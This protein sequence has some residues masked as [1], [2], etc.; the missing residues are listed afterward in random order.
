MADVKPRA[1]VAALL[2]FFE[3]PTGDAFAVPPEQAVAYF[4]AKGLVPT[5]SY[6][7][8]L[9]EAHDHGFTVA[10]MMNIDMLGQV[11]ASL[12][13]A[14]ANGTPFKEWAD[15]IIPM[16]QSG[17]WWGRKAVLDPL[18]GQPMIAQLGSPWR[19]ETIFRTNMQ[20]AY[21]AGQWQEI[22]AQ[23][24][25]APWLMYDAVDDLRTRPMHASWD[26]KVLPVDST[27]WNSHYPPN[28]WNCRCGVIQLADDELEGLGLTP[29]TPPA[30]G[31]YT[32]S[33]PRTGE[34]EQ[35]PKGLD[36]GFD[37]NAGK[38]Y[39]QDLQ[40]LQAEKIAA[41]PKDMEAAAN[42]VAAQAATAEAMK[43]AQQAQEA[44]AAAKAEALLERA[45]AKAAEQ[46]AQADAKAQLEAIAKG[47]ETAGKGA[48]YKIK[49][50]DV[51]KK[52][53][54]W[55]TLKPT[56]Q[57]AKVLAQADE[58]KLKT[59]TASKLSTYKKAVLEG[60]IPAPSLVKALKSLPEA[61]Q[62]AFLA[63]VDQEVAAA[64]A[65]KKAAKE[66]EDL[67][68]A[69][70][71][72]AALDAQK[73]AQAAAQAQAAAV[74]EATAKNAAKA[75]AAEK[76]AQAAAA[77]AQAAAAAPAT[78][79]GAPNPTRL[80]KIGEQRGSNPGGLYQDQDTGVKW[81]IKQ[82]ASVEQARNELL[83]GKLYE[84]AGVEV[85][86][87]HLITMGGKPSLASK[88]IDGLESVTGAQL[89]KAAGA[90]EA[91]A[92][93]AWLANWDVVGQGFDNMLL[94]AGRAIRVDTGGALRF[95]AQGTPKGSAFGPTVPE[96]T[97]LRDGTNRQTAAVFEKIT[98]GQLATSVERVL[99]LS[100]ADIRDLVARYGPTDAAERALLSDT[101]IARQRWLA[102]KFPNAAKAVRAPE[103]PA[104]VE[105]STTT[106]RVTAAEQAEIVRARSNGVGLQTDGDQIEDNMVLVNH[107]ANTAKEPWTRATLK[108]RPDKAKELMAEIEKV[109]EKASITRPAIDVVTASSALVN[110]LKSI[111]FRAVNRRAMDHTTLGKAQLAVARVAETRAK[112]A[113]ALKVATDGRIQLEQIDQTLKEWGE[114]VQKAS[115]TK[116]GEV[117]VR[118]AHFASESLPQ[119][120]YYEI[121]P[122][123][124]L[125]KPDEPKIKWER[126][127][128]EYRYKVATFD[129]GKATEGTK[130]AQVD[131]TSGHY[132]AKLQDGT[133]LTY[134]PPRSDMAYALHGTLKIDIPGQN[135]AATER[136]FTA[137]D[138]LGVKAT[139]ATKTD[140]EILYLNAFANLRLTASAGKQAARTEYFKITA[141][142]EAGVKKRME[143]LKAQTGVDIARS[144]GWKA[145]EGRRE[146]F[147]H[148]MVYQYRPD[149][150]TPEFEAFAKTTTVYH[151]PFGL[152]HDS[153]GNM[154]EKLKIIIGDGGGTA[155]S[156]T[157]R[158]RRG[159]SRSDETSGDSDMNTGGGSYYFTRILKRHHAGTGF[160]W[161]PKILKRMDAISYDGDRFGRVT[162]D[163]SNQNRLGQE[164]SSM[165]AL[166]GRSSNETIFKHGI[167]VFQDL[168]AVVT[169]T[170][171]HRD[172]AIA[173]MKGQ[174][175]A[176]W[177]DGR[178]L[179]DVIVSRDQWKARKR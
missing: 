58:Y 13:S 22:A 48:G 95:R 15:G 81:Y 155:A 18:T 64:A 118:T 23:A 102:E 14:M 136:V 163:Y 156:I 24:E 143:F 121:K 130:F 144:D 40:K 117:P 76:K 71:K 140:R 116:V 127:N 126:V 49:A 46:A 103:P 17:G 123:P 27:W 168:E 173:W 119:L 109:A 61:D 21:A 128:A 77:K 89:A 44:L 84:L 4:K 179:K 26:R 1:S 88:I 154:V 98:N 100:E 93:D 104:P 3:V 80:I 138:E 7:D 108:L 176:T 166:T 145:V 60:K 41:L 34:K 113:E 86:E 75:A 159:V 110:A 97:S 150:D 151:N 68:A 171:A 65:A 87:M 52:K 157:E 149:L 73:A 94:K 131:S 90:T 8:M 47:K 25:I 162:G 152:S 141:T 125:K 129:K 153:N 177:P 67:A 99:R 20:S 6:A 45:K 56:E 50:L 106:S 160:H 69:K 115:L 111:N 107:Y 174:G 175:Y 10:K 172:E 139:R 12:D 114:V 54:E 120:A 59:E 137:L 33:N 2:E 158:I 165:D 74:A 122:P 9:G 38:S 5:F 101:L 105:T 63:K 170:A 72:Q 79:P 178:D 167:S 78:A 30:D 16:L 161:K 37:H 70:A 91:F 92:V 39:L 96:I 32:W 29:S 62:A 135:I 85:P 43:A 112:I 146:G 148:G 42:S 82:P 19:L 169:A 31:T 124:G 35:V 55:S 147:G 51:L 134:F 83:A 28:G 36:P 132:V 142:G 11:R 57:I 66:A 164:V 133:Q 53:P